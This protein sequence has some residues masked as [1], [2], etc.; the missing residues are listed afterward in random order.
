MAKVTIEPIKITR[1]GF[2]ADTNQQ[3]ISLGWVFGCLSGFNGANFAG[4]KS[5]K[6][7]LR[8]VKP[9]DVASLFNE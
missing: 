2:Q 3:G 5:A 7:I 8:G 6:D 9:S 1:E 4:N